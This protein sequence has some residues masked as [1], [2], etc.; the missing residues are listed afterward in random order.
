M[1]AKLA[2]VDVRVEA[3]ARP[4]KRAAGDGCGVLLVAA[5]SCGCL[6]GSSGVGVRLHER[7][8][9]GSRVM[10]RYGR[11]ACCRMLRAHG[12][13]SLQPAAPGP[14][15]ALNNPYEHPC[16]PCEHGVHAGRW[17]RSDARPSTKCASPALGPASHR[18]RVARAP[19][20]RARGGRRRQVNAQM[21]AMLNP[22]RGPRGGQASAACAQ[23]TPGPHPN[24]YPSKP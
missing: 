5:T 4:P 22:D 13:D 20:R 15:R 14:V 6:L 3:S 23:R 8:G 17:R 21:H 9:I 10:S 19:A 11:A 18:P 16:A 12:M 1:G 7:L 2:G 24:A